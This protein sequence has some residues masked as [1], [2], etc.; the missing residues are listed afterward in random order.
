[1]P[2]Y[3]IGVA[4]I[5]G[6]ETSCDETAAAVVE[7]GRHIRANVIASQ[8]DLHAR[9]GGVVPE[10]ASRAHL[11]RIGP[12]IAEALDRA[13]TSFHH[14]DAVAVGHRPGL[15]GS[16]LVGT[17]AAKAIAWG[18]SKPLIGIDHV[19]AHLYGA[20]MSGPQ[21]PELPAVGLVVSGGHTNLYHLTSPTLIRLLGRTIDDA[22]G[23]AFD[24]AATILQ[25]GYPGGPNLDRAA[26]RGDPAG[27]RLPR[28]LLSDKSLDFSFS[29]LKTALLYTVRGRPAKRGAGVPAER[30]AGPLTDQER[31][32][33][34]AAF[35]EAVID[36][37]ITKIARAFAAC[38]TDPSPPRTL[39]VGGGVCANSLLRKRATAWADERQLDLRLPAI[40]LCIDNGSMIAGLGFEYFK[41]GR[42]DTL[43]LP[44][45]ATTKRGK[46][47]E[48]RQWEES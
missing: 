7:Q 5:L 2:R 37:L 22:A 18:T 14:I 45:M 43:D 48:S 41:L 28:S 26:Q 12:V 10:I 29:G 36:V 40:D 13:D 23:E 31:L 20:I 9:Y 33:L 35:Q 34:A 25:L 44:A 6:I 42:F 30:A 39:L 24:K 46:T 3:A 15:I 4:L 21:P 16:L 47:V 32:N 27:H 17:S 1:M 11:E 38:D 8:H 19:H